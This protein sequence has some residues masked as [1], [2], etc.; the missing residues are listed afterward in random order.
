[1]GSTDIIKT[2]ISSTVPFGY[3]NI[4]M[5]LILKNRVIGIPDIPDIPAAKE[6]TNI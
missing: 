3:A 4:I 6:V 5:W 2:K 1:M